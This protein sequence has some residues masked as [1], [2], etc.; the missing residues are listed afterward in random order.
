MIT[1]KLNGLNF[2][3]LVAFVATA[4]RATGFF[5]V[6]DFLATVFFLACA[7]Q[8]FSFLMFY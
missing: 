5:F 6:V 2:L 4:L 8:L 7:I 3:E 1:P